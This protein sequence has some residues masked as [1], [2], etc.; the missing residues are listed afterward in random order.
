MF[1]LTHG[2]FRFF[3]AYFDAFVDVDHIPIQRFVQCMDAFTHG[4][5][6]KVFDDFGQRTVRKIT[7]KIHRKYEK[8]GKYRKN[9][10]SMRKQ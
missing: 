5:T 10:R 9:K 8:Y 6:E 4:S 1:L 7:Q 3:D 2:L